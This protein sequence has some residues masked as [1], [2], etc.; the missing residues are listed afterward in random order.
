MLMRLKEQEIVYLDSC[1][2]LKPETGIYLG[3]QNKTR[4]LYSYK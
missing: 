2:E 1:I 4:G 3:Y